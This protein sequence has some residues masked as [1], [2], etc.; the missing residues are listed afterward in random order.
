MAY[1]MQVSLHEM[2]FI[3]NV[4][5]AVGLN[6]PNLKADVQLVQCLLQ[7][8][9][10]YSIR[11]GLPGLP[12]YDLKPTGYLDAD[13]KE[14][15]Y[16]FEDY[17]RLKKLYFKSDAQIHPSSADGFTKSGVLYK[18]VHLNRAAKNNRGNDFRM[19]PFSDSTPA[20]LKKGILPGA[21]PLPRR[22][23]LMPGF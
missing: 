7:M 9:G 13:T 10:Y 18:I 20:E 22:D 11:A 14:C 21:P 1:T 16:A 23:S 2:P 8:V 17:L 15:L 4:T 6:M 5:N 12:F 19:M 3:Y